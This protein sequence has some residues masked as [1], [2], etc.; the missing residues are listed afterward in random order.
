MEKRRR[1]VFVYS[2]LRRALSQLG[3]DA[4]PVI[5]RIEWAPGLKTARVDFTDARRL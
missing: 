5:R 4:T 1:L 3:P 2:I